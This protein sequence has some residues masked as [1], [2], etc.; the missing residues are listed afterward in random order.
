MTALSAD[1]NTPKR[2]GKQ[3]KYPVLAATKIY[4]GSIVVLDTN[5]WAKPGVTA[6][7][8]ICVGVAQETVDNTSG[9][10]GDLYV[11]V[12]QGVFRLANGESVTKTAIGDLAYI[13]D[14]QTVAAVST[15]KSVAGYFVDVD[16][17]GVWVKIEAGVV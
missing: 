15:G 10:S 6:T 7:G 9:A 1:R 5:G 4:A 2:D 3:F 11:L 8:L 12:E 13:T 14:D 16:T 17:L